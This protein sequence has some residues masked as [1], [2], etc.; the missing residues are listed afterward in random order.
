ML[1]CEFIVFLI[2]LMIENNIFSTIFEVI[3]WVFMFIVH[4]IISVICAFENIESEF[5]I[6]QKRGDLCVDVIQD[7]LFCDH[8]F[9]FVLEGTKHCR[10]CNMCVDK[11]DHHCVWINNCIGAKNYKKFI[12]MITLALIFMMWHFF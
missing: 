4:I 7:A 12:W 1:L 2:P 5:V 11:F 10:R 8:C 3:F 6:F 9:S